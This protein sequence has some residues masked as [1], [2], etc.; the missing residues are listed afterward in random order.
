MD[1]IFVRNAYTRRGYKKIH[2]PTH[3]K[4]L[5]KWDKSF[6]LL[7]FKEDSKEYLTKILNG[8][9]KLKLSSIKKGLQT[10][11]EIHETDYLAEVIAEQLEN[12]FYLKETDLLRISNKQQE[13]LRTK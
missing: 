3:F 4:F 8:E 2:I 10:F 7:K 1:D 5:A 13:R 9:E 11:L 6:A 12:N